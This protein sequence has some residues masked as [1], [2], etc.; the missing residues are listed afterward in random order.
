MS[1]QVESQPIKSRFLPFLDEASEATDISQL[2]R[3]FAALAASFGYDR[4]LVVDPDKLHVDRRQAIIFTV[5][6]RSEFIAYGRANHAVFRH[7]AVHEGPFTFEELR[8]DLDE[9]LAINERTAGTTTRHQDDEFGFHWLVIEDADF[10]DCVAT[11][12][13]VSQTLAEGGFSEQLL[14]AVFGCRPAGGGRDAFFV[15][16]YKRGT[17]Y[18]F[19]P[20]D[21]AQRR[22]NAVELRLKATLA[23]ELPI[24]PEL[25]RWYP[26]WGAPIG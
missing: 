21:G 13:L 25:E 2:G 10:D 17:F 20:A 6:Q 24:E 12:H 15:Y 26:V 3:A 5:Q 4:F 1:V 9:L 23:K 19:V 16:A 22:D 8:R 7:A 11:T 14:C 18:P